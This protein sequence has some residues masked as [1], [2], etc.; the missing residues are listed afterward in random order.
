MGNVPQPLQVCPALELQNACNNNNVWGN[1]CFQTTGGIG[2]QKYGIGVNITNIQGSDGIPS[3]NM[4]YGNQTFNNL[5]NG[6]ED[7]GYTN[8]VHGNT[9][10]TWN[11]TIIRNA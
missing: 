2:F 7:R 4:I 8:D 3:F 1:R 5:L 9:D 11:Q 10:N 6:V